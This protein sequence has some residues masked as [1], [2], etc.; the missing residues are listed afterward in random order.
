MAGGLTYTSIDAVNLTTAEV[1][2][3][4]LVQLGKQDPTIVGLSADLAK[5]TKISV[6]AKNRICS[7]SLPGWQKR[8]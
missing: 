6:F 8:G 2:G 1:Y 7:A 3:Q 4:T 5:S